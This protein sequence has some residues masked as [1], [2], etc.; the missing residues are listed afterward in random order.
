MKHLD[1]I[2]ISIIAVLIAGGVILNVKKQYSIDKSKLP[3][4]LE[5]NSQFQKWIT[6]ARNKGIKVEGDN[7]RFVEDSNIFNTLWTST[8]SVDDDA[9]RKLYDQNMIELKKFK[10]SALSPNER[11]VVNYDSSTRF[12][13]LPTEVFFYGLREDK[14]LRTK[15]TDCDFESNCFFNRASFLDNHVFFVIQMSLKD[16]T[17]KD[18]KT[19][20][21]TQVCTYTFKVH[22]IDLINNSRTVYESEPIQGV[23]E[24]LKSK[25]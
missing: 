15:I 24:D 2:L 25:L 11:E 17:K 20:N 23:L 8:A 10:T 13:F 1:K 7:F 22:L 4:K 16:Y 12:G 18:P 19:C 6:N 9:S 14:I 3:N 5:T 21:P